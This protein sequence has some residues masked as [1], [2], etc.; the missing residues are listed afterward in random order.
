VAAYWRF[1]HGTTETFIEALRRFESLSNDEMR[2]LAEANGN[3][4]DDA[5][6]R[7]FLRKKGGA[8]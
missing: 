7:S 2:Q 5:A 6:F 3:D 1:D 8:R 4:F